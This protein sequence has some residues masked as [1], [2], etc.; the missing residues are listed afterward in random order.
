M[1]IPLALLLS[2][3][4]ADATLHRAVTEAIEDEIEYGIEATIA[5]DIERY[6]ETVPDDY[7]IVEDDG[8]ITDRDALRRNQLQAWSIILRTNTLSI[9]ITRVDVGCEGQCATVWTDQRWDRQMRGRD[10]VS[11]HNVVTTQ[12]RQE[13]WEQRDARWVNTDIIELGGTVT[14][15]GET[16]R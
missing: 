7:R 6:M 11:E 13:Q 1:L 12:Q 8:T 4:A 14:V 15:D 9:D 10:G 2:A 16:Y 3:G 5:Q